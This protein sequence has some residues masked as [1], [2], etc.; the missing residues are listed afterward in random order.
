MKKK[1]RIP[2]CMTLLCISISLMISAQ[3]AEAAGSSYLYKSE[4]SYVA[5]ISPIARK[6]GLAYD[7]LPS[8]L[9]AQCILETGYGG[10][11]DASTKL[12]IKYNNHLGMKS[13]LINSTWAGHS[14]WPGKSFTKKTPEWYGGRNIYIR[15]RFRKYDSVKQCLIDYVMFMTWAKRAS[16]VYKYRDDVIGNPSYKKTI[17]AV[18]VNGYCTDPVYDKSIIRIIRKWNLTRLDSGFGVRVSSVKLN[19]K[20]AIR[21]SVGKT[22]KL[23]AAVIPSNAARPGVRW[24]SSN[25][26][27]ASVKKGLITAKH[28]GTAWI[29]ARSKDDPEITAR[30]KV[31][32]R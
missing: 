21:L 14:V 22:F 29:T 5:M 15:D 13:S 26:L 30:V 24:K 31:V 25:S 8:V 4:E 18:R 6:V 19:R 12:M 17:R 27:V 7:Y 23:K 9:A 11:V 2:F 1:L 20:K 10:Y 16:G 3:P 32:V 28:A